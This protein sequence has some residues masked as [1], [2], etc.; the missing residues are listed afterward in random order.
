MVLNKP[1]PVR[2]VRLQRNLTVNTV[3]IKSPEPLES[4]VESKSPIVRNNLSRSE[5]N[6]VVQVVSSPDY[7]RDLEYAIAGKKRELWGVLGANDHYL[8]Y[9]KLI[10]HNPQHSK[11]ES[12]GFY[13][14]CPGSSAYEYM[15][16]NDVKYTYRLKENAG[17]FLC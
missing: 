14:N 3:V 11:L 2:P 7:I 4:P 9:V 10:T 16:D 15:F 5:I 8:K 13:T 12:E 17:G 1:K 6:M